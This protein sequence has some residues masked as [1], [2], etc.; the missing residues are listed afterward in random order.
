L[1]ALNLS[2][3]GLDAV[4][5]WAL[6]DGSRKYVLVL[7]NA[8]LVE[9]IKLTSAEHL[10]KSMKRPETTDESEEAEAPLDPLSVTVT[11]L[12]SSAV[13]QQAADDDE[14]ISRC[15][16]WLSGEFE[17]VSRHFAPWVGIPE[18]PVTGAAHVVVAPYWI[19]KTRGALVAG[20]A[21]SCY[22]ASRR[23]GSMLCVVKPHDR[24]GLQGHAV[25]FSAGHIFV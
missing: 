24:I 12:V 19:T 23:G 5:G 22:Q 14:E 9:R 18:D 6:H 17:V 11:A 21:I 1:D 13:P 4:G 2:E 3:V 7:K 16:R 25:T 15:A 20:S 8:R 10:V